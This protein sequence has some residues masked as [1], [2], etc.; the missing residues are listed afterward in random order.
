MSIADESG[1]CHGRDCT[2][3]VSSRRKWCSD[4]CRKQTMYGQP[5]V[6]CGR[7]TNGSD[8]KRKKP[9]CVPCAS[10][11]VIARGTRSDMVRH[12]VREARIREMW[13]DGAT[14]KAIAAALDTTP[15]SI[16]T[17]IHRMRVRG[18]DVAYRRWRP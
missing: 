12:A 3:P 7:L 14:M 13:A 4:R 11:A 1:T 8:G 9:R 5:C 2:N 15:T 16:S 10:L 6:D 17:D 18:V